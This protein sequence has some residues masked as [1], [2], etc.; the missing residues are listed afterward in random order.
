MQERRKIKETKY[1]KALAPF[2]EG[3][4][5]HTCTKSS[6]YRAISF[7]I[8]WSFLR[9][10]LGF[11]V[12]KVTEELGIVVSP[13]K[14]C[15]DLVIE[16]FRGGQV[17]YDSWSKMSCCTPGVSD[18]SLDCVSYD[19]SASMPTKGTRANVNGS[20]LAE[21]ADRP[22]L[23]SQMKDDLIAAL[24]FFFV[25]PL[26]LFFSVCTCF[27]LCVCVCGGGGGCSACLVFNL[28][29]LPFLHCELVSYCKL[30]KHELSLQY[31]LFLLL[32]LIICILP[33][34]SNVFSFSP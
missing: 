12:E 2:G 34:F 25:A 6:L 15:G 10:I 3:A 24:T 11:Q 31:S 5:S 22:G 26:V 29:F 30:G 13:W 4:F 9:R 32:S 21:E 20:N 8:R 14:C 27:F 33:T 28:S 23:R 1:Q 19:F 17:V 16:H 18:W 7:H